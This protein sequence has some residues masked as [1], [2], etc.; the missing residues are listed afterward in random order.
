MSHRAQQI[1]EAVVAALQADTALGATVYTHRQYSLSEADQELPAVS[2]RIGSDM[3]TGEFG[4]DNFAFIDSVLELVVE[5]SVKAGDEQTAAN[6]LLDLRRR[7]HIDLMADRTQA[8]S[9]VMDTR[10]G[11][12]TA[13]DFDVSTD[14]PVARLE[15]RWGVFYRMNLTDPN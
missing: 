6:S 5:I 15:T 12:A 13:P 14:R 1:V 9:F 10:Y 4:P 8:L 2:V 3:P 11:G 7:V